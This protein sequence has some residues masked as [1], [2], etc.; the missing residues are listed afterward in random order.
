MQNS[1][2]AMNAT[3]AIVCGMLLLVFEREGGSSP[4]R[5][6]AILAAFPSRS[7]CAGSASKR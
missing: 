2:F 3:R 5:N 7:T 1:K 6:H 4:A